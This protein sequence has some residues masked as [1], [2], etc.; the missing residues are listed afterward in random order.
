MESRFPNTIAV[1]SVQEV[2]LDMVKSWAQK[3]SQV[4]LVLL[5]GGPPCQGVSGLN[6]ARKGALRDARSSLFTHVDRIRALVK[7]AFPWAQV[8]S[9]MESVASMSPTDRDI[10]SESFG[11]SPWAIDAV[12]VSMARR[13][14]LY[15]VD[16]ELP[17]GAGAEVSGSSTTKAVRLGGAMVRRGFLTARLDEGQLGSPFQLL[18][19]HVLGKNLGTS[20]L[21]YPNARLLSRNVGGMT[22]IGFRHI[23]IGIVLLWSTNTE[24]HRVPEYRG[25]R[26]HDGI[27]S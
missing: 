21:V 1:N 12:Q 4:G 2:S 27:P 7:Q 20:L 6:A 10:M 9:L 8:K 19:R 22:A 16:W 13:P 5:G 24:I 18:P 25:T 14:R 15:W 3:F 26:G 17:A 23:S 11:D